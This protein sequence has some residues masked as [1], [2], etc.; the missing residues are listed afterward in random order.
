MNSH[1]R[2]GR[3]KDRKDSALRTKFISELPGS[4]SKKGVT[5]VPFPEGLRFVCF[6]LHGNSSGKKTWFPLY[7]KAWF[8]RHTRNLS[9]VLAL[10]SHT[11]MTRRSE[12][13]WLLELLATWAAAPLWRSLTLPPCLPPLI[14]NYTADAACSQPS[15]KAACPAGS[16]PEKQE[17]RK[18]LHR[19]SP[20][21]A[22]LLPRPFHLGSCCLWRW[23]T[24]SHLR[25]NQIRLI[26]RAPI[27][28]IKQH[29]E[30]WLGSLP[31]S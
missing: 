11:P 1:S 4:Q 9:V 20:V 17:Q 2:G 22:R 31:G 3:N 8:D 28:P 24:F 21:C 30:F 23:L 6:Q 5:T 29:R 26:K 18:P 14:S 12:R 13:R 25:G 19:A 7:P 16:W 27:T 15:F 10:C